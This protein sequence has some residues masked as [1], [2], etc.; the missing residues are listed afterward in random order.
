MTPAAL[1]AVKSSRVSFARVLGR[2]MIEQ[3]W[4]I[5]RESFVCDAEG[6]A[7]AVYAI[8]IGAHR[9]TYAMRSFQW[10][11]VEKVGRRSDGAVRDMFGAIFLGAPSPERIA[12]EFETFDTRNADIMRTDSGVTGWTP[13]SRSAR[14]FDHVVDSLSAGR[15]PDPEVIGAGT[16]YLLR[17]GGYL[18]SGRNGT[19]SYE[20]YGAD[21]PL[22]H[23]FFADLFGLYMVRQASID[24][25]DGIAAARNP[26]AA[27]LA[28]D[29]A[30][31]LGV[32]NS[33]GQGMCVAL[34]RW[35]HWV[36]TWMT[37]R[38]LS[39]AYAKSMPISALGGRA[40]R[41]VELLRRAA[42]YYLSVKVQC[43]DYVAPHETLAANLL[44]FADWT[45]TAARGAAA[46]SIRWAD[47]VTHAERD[48]DPES[49][50]QVHSLL[51]ELYPDFADATAEYLPIGANRHR[52]VTPE[53]SVAN[54][55]ALLRRNYAWALKTDLSLSKT[56]QHFWYHSIDNGEQRRGERIIDPHEQF[57]SFIDHIGV[58][59]RLASALACHPDDAPVAELVADMPEMA[60]PLSRAQY[61]DGL[62]YCE[63]RGSLLHRDFIPAHLIRFFLGVLG[64]ECTNPLSIRYV[65]GVFFPGMPLPAELARGASED[66]T[67][68]APPA[69][70]P[71]DDLTVS[72]PLIAAK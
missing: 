7:K 25:V 12:R 72:A 40:D 47:L 31:F 4:R 6:D 51:I 71:G 37:V 69:P 46:G 35:P 18:G 27:R 1:S 62:P 60:F 59:Q 32:G 24:L 52:D 61:L 42:A 17:N 45:E 23:P 38:E 49:L 21:H 48:F 41:L 26:N 5:E 9:L 2:R 65:R 22:R 15:Q 63:I 28:P 55:R 34:Q 19:L 67:F 70:K 39:L 11:G 53:M 29:L 33:S 58:I 50:E 10:D 13:G 8:T 56:R 44:R 54:A 68:P 66:W 43:E 64:M 57:E 14:F 30:R 20:G 36:S 3:K 16:G